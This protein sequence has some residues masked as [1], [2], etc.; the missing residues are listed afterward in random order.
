M[1]D[2]EQFTRE[3][4]YII[5]H[6]LDYKRKALE[7]QIVGSRLDHVLEEAQLIPKLDKL[8]GKVADIQAEKLRQI[9]K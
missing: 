7:S 4:I 2:V 8:Q 9:E 3:E 6:A 5:Y 1:D